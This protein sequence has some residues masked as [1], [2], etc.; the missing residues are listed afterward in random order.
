MHGQ[1][2]RHL[3]RLLTQKRFGEIGGPCATVNCCQFGI[4]APLQGGDALPPLDRDNHS[5]AA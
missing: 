3:I 4:S 5:A 1:P 2:R